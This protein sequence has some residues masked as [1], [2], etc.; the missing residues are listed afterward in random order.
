MP[1]EHE[2][3]DTTK[4]RLLKWRHKRRPSADGTQFPSPVPQDF[5]K[6]QKPPDKLLF[7]EKKKGEEERDQDE[8]PIEKVVKYQADQLSVDLMLNKSINIFPPTIPEMPQTNS[9][10]SSPKEQ[11][12]KS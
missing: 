4:D 7:T 1:L 6:N 10:E 11:N 12:R 5:L 3:I 8:V 9:P 2:Q